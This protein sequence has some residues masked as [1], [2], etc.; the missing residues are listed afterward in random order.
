MKSLKWKE[1]VMEKMKALKK[2]E[3]YEVVSLPKGKKPVKCK[4]IFNVK[5]KANGEIKCYKLV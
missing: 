2:N 4:W 3:T 1:T 5:Y